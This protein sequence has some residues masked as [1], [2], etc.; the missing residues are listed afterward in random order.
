MT[1]FNTQ[2]IDEFRGNDGKVGGPFEGAPLLCCTTRGPRAALSASPRSCTSGG[3]HLAVFA[4]KGGAPTNPDWY[5]NLVAH[6]QTTM[7]VGPRRSP[8][9]RRSPRT[10]NGHPSGRSRRSGSRLR[11]VRAQDD[12]PDPGRHP[13]AR[14]GL[15]LTGVPTAT[16]VALSVTAPVSPGPVAGTSRTAARLGRRRRSDTTGLLESHAFAFGHRRLACGG[17]SALGRGTRLVGSRGAYPR[18]LHPRLE[19]RT[20]TVA[21]GS[22]SDKAADRRAPLR[23]DHRC[24]LDLGTRRRR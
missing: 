23:V 3:R 13:G 10:T 20:A 11:R 8:S 1:D 14:T 5:H 2:I 15:V 18:R 9:S 4:S 22:A 21:P 17:G 24:T 12:A 7:E 16:S 19:S 6:P